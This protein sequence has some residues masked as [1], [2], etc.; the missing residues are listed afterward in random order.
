MGT[1]KMIMFSICFM[2]LDICILMVP[3]GFFIGTRWLRKK[4]FAG[5]PTTKP[6]LVL[7][8][9]ELINVAV[10]ITALYF[11]S[12]GGND[13][14]FYFVAAFLAVVSLGSYLLLLF[15]LPILN[16]LFGLAWLIY[17]NKQRKP[18]EKKHAM[19]WLIAEA[20]LIG[21]S[22]AILSKTALWETLRTGIAAVQA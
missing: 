20:A 6:T 9:A 13:P 22:L 16:L 10:I 5:F 11:L 19:I 7:I 18:L 1:I 8:L 4:N 12:K 14:S 3:T 15:G 2:L 17:T 21:I